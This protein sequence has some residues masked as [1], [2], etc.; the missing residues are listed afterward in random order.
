MYSPYH[1]QKKGSLFIK[2]KEATGLLQMNPQGLTDSAVRIFLL[3]KR[4]PYSKKKTK[5]IKNTLDPVWNEDFE[6]KYVTLEELKSSRVLEL[7]LWD[8]DRRGCN[9]FI[10]CVRL[11]PTP[12]ETNSISKDWMDSTDSEANHWTEMLAHPGEWMEACHELQPS[13]AS[14]FSEYPRIQEESDFSLDSDEG[15]ENDSDEV[16]KC[17]L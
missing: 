9:D 12:D 2:I 11:G 8:Y 10:G 3:P 6:Y 17:V 1:D 5:C 14:R 15:G 16:R 7:S 13:I 4:N